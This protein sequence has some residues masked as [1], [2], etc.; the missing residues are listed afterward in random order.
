MALIDALFDFVTRQFQG[1]LRPSP[2]RNGGGC[3]P[4][5]DLDLDRHFLAYAVQVGALASEFG[6]RRFQLRL[7]HVDLVAVRRGVDFGD[8]L[9]LLDLIILIGQKLDHSPRDDLRRDVDDVGLNE[10]VVGDRV[11]SPEVDPA[12]SSRKADREEG[13]GERQRDESAG[14]SQARR[15]DAWLGVVVGC[16]AGSCPG[17]AGG[18]CIVLIGVDPGAYVPS[19]M[20]SGSHGHR[21]VADSHSVAGSYDCI[22]MKNERR[23][24]YL[25]R[26][27]QRFSSSQPSWHI[28]PSPSIDDVVSKA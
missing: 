20:M 27:T 4:P 9:S 21:R 17:G 13:N 19:L 15:L 25:D 6:P 2:I 23:A 3:R 14:T 7:R 11:G 5:G 18:A 12:Q 22:E 24:C 28:F 16:V 10:R 26:A 1:F 8:D